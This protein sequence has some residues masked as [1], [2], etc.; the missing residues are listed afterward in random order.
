MIE[1]MRVLRLMKCAGKLKTVLA[2]KAEVFF[3]AKAFINLLFL[4]EA[5][6]SN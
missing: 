2:S 4:L 6:E 5:W 3:R 1:A